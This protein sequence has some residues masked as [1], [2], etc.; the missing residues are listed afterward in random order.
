MPLR[1]TEMQ[2]GHNPRLRELPTDWLAGDA[3]IG[4]LH[5]QHCNLTS[6]AL[7]CEKCEWL[8]K[9]IANNN[10]IT[11]LEGFATPSARL[12]MLSQLHLH[13]NLISSL[14]LRE[15]FGMNGGGTRLGYF[16]L[17]HNRL[18]SISGL[19][20]V[21]A[22]TI[23]TGLFHSNNLTTGLANIID[24]FAVNRACANLTLHGNNFTGTPITRGAE[25][26]AQYGTIT[27]D[28]TGTAGDSVLPAC[29]I[30]RRPAPPGDPG[31]APNG[32]WFV[33]QS[34]SNFDS[35]TSTVNLEGLGLDAFADDALAEEPGVT[36]LAMPYNK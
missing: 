18:Q 31:S 11:T 5:L 30:S 13:H 25:V 17:D 4:T 21:G 24:E 34:C 10:R 3:K 33:V 14:P 28:A 29:Y 12:I 22:N 16:N 6:L 27:V 32:D 36:S 35:F 8:S 9:V 15:L 2:L 1:L 23:M 20:M 19:D 26:R 7:G